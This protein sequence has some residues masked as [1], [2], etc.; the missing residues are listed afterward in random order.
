MGERIR[1]FTWSAT[2]LGPVETWPAPLR[3]LMGV[4]LAAEQPMFVAWGPERILIYNDAYAPLL[5]ARAPDA[6]RNRA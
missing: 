2:P 6:S 4:L 3:T 1:A 5:E